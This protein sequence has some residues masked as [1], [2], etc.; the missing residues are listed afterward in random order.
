M[1]VV[2]IVVM[3]GRDIGLEFGASAYWEGDLIG[4]GDSLHEARWMA[5]A[6]DWM[7]ELIDGGCAAVEI[8]VPE[9]S[10]L[11]LLLFF[12]G[13]GDAGFCSGFALRMT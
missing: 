7:A 6:E 9:S 5:I 4:V 12:Q 13:V 11:F 8:Y 10:L 3:N 2:V 1:V